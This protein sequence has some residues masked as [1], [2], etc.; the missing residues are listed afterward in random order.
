MSSKAPRPLRLRLAEN[1]RQINERLTNDPTAVGEI[2]RSSGPFLEY[3]GAIGVLAFD[4]AV[5]EHHHLVS[6]RT[7]HLLSGRGLD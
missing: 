3:L 2:Y 5:D 1:L 6:V 7:C 4:F